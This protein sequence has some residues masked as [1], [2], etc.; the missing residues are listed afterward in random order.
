MANVELRPGDTLEIIWSSTQDTPFGAKKI[1]SSFAFS[2][3]DLLTK[4]KSRSKSG[5]SRR[6]GTEGARFSRMVALAINAIKKGKWST[7]ADID[8]DEVF[9]RLMRKFNILNDNEYAFI[10]LNAKK[11]LLQLYSG[12]LLLKQEQKDQLRMMLEAIASKSN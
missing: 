6:S 4:L 11:A 7:G 9:E 2:Y 1:E 8:K 3:D 10:T 12:K 5:T